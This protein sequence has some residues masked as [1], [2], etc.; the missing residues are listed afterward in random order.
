MAV[1]LTAKAVENAKAE[2]GRRVELWDSV[3]PGLVLRVGGRRK[4]WYAVYRLAGRRQWMKLG[5]SP[6]VEL[7]EAR[8][9]ARAALEAL[10]QQ[11]DPKAQP[12]EIVPDE[13]RETLKAVVEDYQRLYIGVRLKKATGAAYKGRLTRLVKKYGHKPIPKVTRRDILDHTEGLVA[14]G[15][16]A[17]AAYVHRILAGF[18]NWCLARGLINVSPMHGMKPPA[19][20]ASRDRVLTDDEVRAVWEAAAGLGYPYGPFVRMLLATGQREGEVA[21]MRRDQVDGAAWTMPDTKRGTPHRV[22]LPGLARRVLEECPKFEGP[23]YFTSGDG[24]KS[25]NGFS[26]MKARL[27]DTLGDQLEPWRLHDLRRTVASGMAK[28][29][30]QPH[31]IEAVLNHRS[32]TVSGIARVYNRYSYETEGADALARWAR[33]LEAVT[34]QAPPAAVVSLR[35]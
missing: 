32:G 34:G 23:H 33:H 13:G 10:E 24:K 27:D 25:I 14:E 28:L 19:K 29:G 22:I 21:R 8:K 15:K 2:A 6:A 3:V 17:E 9:S 20:V 26:K 31:V 30:T 16:A 35:R 5:H 7:A 11:E 1:K 18:F 4:T 12:T